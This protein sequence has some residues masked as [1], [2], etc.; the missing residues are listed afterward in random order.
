VAVRARSSGG[1]SGQHFLRSSRLAAD[2]VSDAEV[3]ADD[4]IVEIG[5]G[6]GVLTQALLRAGAVVIAIERDP[7]LATALRNRFREIEV[8]TGDATTHAWPEEPFSVVA[9]LPFVGSGAILAHLLRDPGRPLR[10]AEV[11]VQ[12][13]FAAKHSAVW[14]ATLRSTYWR[15][16]YEV[17]I[18]RRLDRTAFAPPPS[19]DAAVLRFTRRD[20]ARVPAGLYADYW[21]F[22]TAGFALR[23]PIRNGL[24]PLLSPLQVKRL[25]PVLGFRLDARARDLDAEQWAR[26]FAAAIANR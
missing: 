16:W 3:G 12:W 7:A 21:D 18:V 19:V 9:N 1:A 11:I 23:S 25:A 14:P 2:L 6:T 4:L 26:L 8:V 17:A 10:R 13:E 5:G 15:A 24:R 22:L 20:R